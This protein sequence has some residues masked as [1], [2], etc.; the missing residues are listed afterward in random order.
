MKV[1]TFIAV[2]VLSVLLV[3]LSGCVNPPVC[4]NGLCEQ[5]ENSYNCPQ[6]CGMPPVQ[7][8]LTVIVSDA[9][10]GQPIAFAEVVVAG[11]CDVT[12]PCGTAVMKETDKMGEASFNLNTGRYTVGVSKEEYIPYS[13]DIAI[14]AGELR[15]MEVELKK[16]TP[17]E[18][19]EE[20]E[21]GAVYPGIECCPGLDAGSTS[22]PE[23]NCEILVGAFVC[24]NCGNGECGPGENVCNCPEDCNTIAGD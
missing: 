14:G 4:G 12:K 8:N 19:I 17:S 16:E 1:K 6:D 2:S 24:I 5:G 21:T 23:Q 11:A 3:M 9:D 22:T 20:G 18:C 10:S 15:R 13:E 7:G